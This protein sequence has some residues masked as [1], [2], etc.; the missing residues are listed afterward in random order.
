MVQVTSCQEVHHCQLSEISQTGITRKEEIEVAESGGLLV[1]VGFK[2]KTLEEAPE[3]LSCEV[4]GKK[5]Y[6]VL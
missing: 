4:V 3:F 6:F 5:E 2:P 1:A